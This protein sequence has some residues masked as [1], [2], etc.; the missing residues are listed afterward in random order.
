MDRYGIFGDSKQE[1]LSAWVW[2]RKASSIRFLTG[3]IVGVGWGGIL[4]SVA[5]HKEVN[6]QSKVRQKRERAFLILQI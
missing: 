5:C 6:V 2:Q 3:A 1:V 4:L